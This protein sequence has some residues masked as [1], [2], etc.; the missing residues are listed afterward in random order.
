MLTILYFYL[1]IKF[2]EFRA[3]IIVAQVVTNTEQTK[4]NSAQAMAMHI[5]NT[6]TTKCLHSGPYSVVFCFVFV[7]LFI[8]LF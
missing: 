5:P 1:K 6:E 4:N 2:Y 8:C 7:C 3:V